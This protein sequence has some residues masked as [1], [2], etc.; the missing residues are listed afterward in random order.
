[1]RIAAAIVAAV[2]TMGAAGAETPASL[3]AAWA[4]DWSGKKLDHMMGL[5]A[6]DPVFLPT[7]G[8]R[9]E[10]ARIIRKNF[11]SGLAQ[12][13]ADLHLHSVRSES[14]GTLAY[15]SGTYDETVMPVKAGKPMHVKGN[16][17][18]VFTRERGTWR[19]RE[20]TFTE[21]DAGKL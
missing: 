20:Q 2:V 6:A 10:G 9:W 14:S 21:Y 18:F 11:A 7:S 15:D 13:T 19:I 12:F 16:Y 17:L 8:E 5:Y 4:A 1:M 3:S